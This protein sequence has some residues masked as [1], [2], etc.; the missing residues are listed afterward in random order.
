MA[1]GVLGSG[2]ATGDFTRTIYTCPLTVQYAVL[3][4]FYNLFV[5]NASGDAAAIVEGNT[6]S[7]ISSNTSTAV[8]DRGSLSVILGP[9]ESIQMVTSVSLTGQAVASGWVTGYEVP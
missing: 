9:G 6:V 1:A 8:T 2:S 7:S 5:R 4:F 3:H